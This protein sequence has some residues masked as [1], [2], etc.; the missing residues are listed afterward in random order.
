MGAA[1][2]V[3]RA[4]SPRPA[5]SGTSA[6]DAVKREG[7]EDHTSSAGAYLPAHSSA[8]MYPTGLVRGIGESVRAAPGKPEHE[9][10]ARRDQANR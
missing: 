7:R 5:E 10:A 8:A 6:S 1:S 9:P 4:T 2:S 3:L